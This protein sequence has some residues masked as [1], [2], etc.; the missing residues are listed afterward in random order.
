MQ[1]IPHDLIHALQLFI[2]SPDLFLHGTLALLRRSAKTGVTQHLHDTGNHRER[3]LEAV[4]QI[5]KSFAIPLLLFAL[6]LDE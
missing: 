5:T 2:D 6:G 4:R 3:R 1:L